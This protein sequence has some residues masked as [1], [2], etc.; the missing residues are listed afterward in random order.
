MIARGNLDLE[1]DIRSDTRPLV[2][3]NAE[4]RQQ[5]LNLLL[6]D[7]RWLLERANFV[8]LSVQARGQI[9]VKLVTRINEQFGM[10]IPPEVFQ[11]WVHPWKRILHTGSDSTATSHLHDNVSGRPSQ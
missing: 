2:Q 7:F 9:R 4:M 11:P 1:A 10:H 3:L 8:H 5:R 6:C